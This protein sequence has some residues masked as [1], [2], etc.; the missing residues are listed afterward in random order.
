MGLKPGCPGAWPALRQLGLLPMFGAITAWMVHHG[1]PHVNLLPHE[2]PQK[3]REMEPQ[4][5]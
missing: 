2:I 1:P 4:I 5:W 3:K